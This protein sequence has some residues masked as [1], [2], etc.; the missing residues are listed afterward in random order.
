MRLLF[1]LLVFILSV[2][3]GWQKS[4]PL[5]KRNEFYVSFNN[6]NL[7]YKNAVSFNK[8]PISKVVDELNKKD[9]FYELLNNYLRNSNDN[10][11][12]NYLTNDERAFI[13]DYL[14]SIGKGDEK[15]QLDYVDHVYNIIEDKKKLCNEYEKKFSGMYLKLSI[16]IG[17]MLFIV[18][19]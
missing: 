10:I 11:N 18:V 2:Y 19:I 9:D 8:K 14:K 16:L 4:L 15:S 5:K 7:V 3:L 1:G 6:F 17:L 12:L 13:Q